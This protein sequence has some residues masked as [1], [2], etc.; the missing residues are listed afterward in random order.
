MM[1]AGMQ[2]IFN[3]LTNLESMR[4]YGYSIL[5]VVLFNLSCESEKKAPPL[6]P[7]EVL[8]IYQGHFDKN[9][10]DEAIVYST[11]EGREW[12]QNIAP[13]IS[14]EFGEETITTTIFHSIDCKI[15]S[16]T[17]NCQCIL[18]DEA[19]TYE[20]SYRLIRI[21]GYWLVD[22][23]D[24]EHSIEYEDREEIFEDGY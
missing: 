18:E 8:K 3:E 19:E 4:R 11:V 15:V 14:G 23:P 6:P 10:F 5:L 9:E 17:A 2:N 24:E 13:M 7:E 16:D 12:I 20:A 21:D 22:A 1:N